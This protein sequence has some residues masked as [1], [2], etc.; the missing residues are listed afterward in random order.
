MPYRKDPRLLTEE[1]RII[2]E[3]AAAPSLIGK[4]R[5]GVPRIDTYD[6]DDE[7]SEALQAARDE[8]SARGT[9]TIRLYLIHDGMAPKHI[10]VT[11]SGKSDM[12]RTYSQ[13]LP[14]P[15]PKQIIDLA[16]ENQP[17]WSWQHALINLDLYMGTLHTLMGLAGLVLV[18][19]TDH[20]ATQVLGVL[21]LLVATYYVWHVVDKDHQSHERSLTRVETTIKKYMRLHPDIW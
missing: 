16:W 19:L 10:V 11:L 8:A 13:H 4:E 1:E 9:H 5:A 18:F 17:T 15:L 7:T 20:W 12:M 2:F 14:T 6:L 21:L 3:T